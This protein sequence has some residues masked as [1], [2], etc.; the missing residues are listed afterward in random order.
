MKIPEQIKDSSFSDY[1]HHFSGV[2]CEIYDAKQYEGF[3]AILTVYPADYSDYDLD[4]SKIR[5]FNVPYCMPAGMYGFT[6]SMKDIYY[7]YVITDRPSIIE[8]RP[9]ILVPKSFFYGKNSLENNDSTSEPNMYSKKELESI[10]IR[11]DNLIVE[12]SMFS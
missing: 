5:M 9:A 2:L 1:R 3:S 11:K 7:A 4:L 6:T 12:R 8:G 10:V